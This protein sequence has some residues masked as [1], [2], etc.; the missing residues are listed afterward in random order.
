MIKWAPSRAGLSLLFLFLGLIA[1]FFAR[2]TY[3]RYS[4]VEIAFSSKTAPVVA[5]TAVQATIKEL[6]AKLDKPKVGVGRYAVTADKNLF[7]ADRKAWQPPAPK[8]P[9]GEKKEEAAA[10]S[11]ARVRRDVILYGTYISGSVKK[12]LLHFKRFR[13]GRILVAEGEEANDEEGG[14]SGK[15][16]TPVYTLLKV[17]AK[18]VT[19]KDERGGEFEISLY[20]NK[21]RRPAKTSN[22]TNIQV[23]TPAAPTARQTRAQPARSNPKVTGAKTSSAATSSLSAKQIRKL[24]VEEKNALVERGE[25]KRHSTPFGPVYKRIRKK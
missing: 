24:S 2:Y 21:K 15:R 16:K 10:P 18:K 9:A 6:S 22:K 11:A 12:A 13:K 17:E 8:V 19:L 1:L 23:G 4:G 7:A 14:S 20:D 3:K 5:G 25:L